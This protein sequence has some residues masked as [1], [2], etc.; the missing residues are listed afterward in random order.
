MLPSVGTLG[1][2]S[3]VDGV[4]D[5]VGEQFVLLGAD[6]PFEVVGDASRD[7]V[8]CDFLS[9]LPGEQYKRKMGVLLSNGLQELQPARTGHTVVRDNT[10]GWPVADDLQSLISARGRLDAELTVLA[11]E[12]RCRQ[13][14]FPPDPV[15]SA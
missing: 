3:C 14:C 10:V 7:G 15:A 9:S 1:L 6:V 12:N 11:F 8:A 2:A 13:V 4:A 5:P